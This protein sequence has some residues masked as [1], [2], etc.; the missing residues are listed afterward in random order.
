MSEKYSQSSMIEILD[1]STKWVKIDLNTFQFNMGVLGFI[2]TMEVN[3]VEWGVNY[4]YDEQSLYILKDFLRTADLATMYLNAL[5]K[6]YGDYSKVTKLIEFNFDD[7]KTAVFK[8]LDN[9]CDRKTVTKICALLGRKDINEKA[10]AFKKAKDGDKR[11]L[12]SELV[13][14]IKSDERALKYLLIGDIAWDKMSYLF[15]NMAF[16]KFGQGSYDII[17]T[18]SFEEQLDKAIFNIV[19]DGLD[20]EVK[21]ASGFCFECDEAINKRE[22]KMTF[23]RDCIADMNKKTS[24]FWNKKADSFVCPLCLMIYSFMP[25]GAIDMKNTLVFVNCNDS[26]ENMKNLNDAISMKEEKNAHYTAY[27]T[28]LQRLLEIKLYELDNIQIIMKDKDNRYAVDII[29]RDKLR[30]IATAKNELEFISKSFIKID[31]ENYM[32]LY[33]EVLSN[34]IMGV[35]QYQIIDKLCR[36]HY[37]YSFQAF[38]ILKIQNKQSNN[39]GEKEVENNL[40]KMAYAV[41]NSG[42]ELRNSMGMEADNKLRGFVYQLLN[43][44]HSGNVDMFHDRIIRMYAGM[45]KP[46]PDIFINNYKGEEEFK[47]LAYAYIMGLKGENRNLDYAN[48]ENKKEKD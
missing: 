30:I 17:A 26:I 11:A 19:R 47:T 21:N 29:G 38:Q 2:Y 43:A 6:K 14:L 27:N 42:S 44:V 39:K 28:I 40:F 1:K 5:I 16:L 34:I 33:K 18:E 10:Q 13:A 8:D 9:Y 25:L 4:K 7:E 20:L 46:I 3:D 12:G 36:N 23:I 41:K 48:K 15:R 24:V 22:N 45:Q 35:N 37:N 32:N 31:N